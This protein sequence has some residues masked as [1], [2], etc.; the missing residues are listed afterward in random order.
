MY[1]VSGRKD[2]KLNKANG[3]LMTNV[4]MQNPTE[5]K[6][7]KIKEHFEKYLQAVVDKMTPQTELTEA[8]RYALLSGGKRWR[9]LLLFMIAEALG[10][11]DKLDDAAVA[12]EMFH[13]ASLIADDLPSMDND[14]FR[15]GQPTVHKKFGEA[16]AIMASYALISEGYSAIYRCTL[17]LSESGLESAET[18]GLLAV[19]CVAHNAGIQG[20]TGGQ[21]FDLK[22]QKFSQEE[23]L[24]IHRQ[25]TASIF[26]ISLVL[27]WLF[28]GG[29]LE[30]L[31]LVQKLAMNFGTAFQ[32]VDD[33]H[34]FQQDA[35]RL[36][37]VNY[38]QSFGVESAKSTIEKLVQ[39]CKALLE[40]L[41]IQDSLLNPLMQK[42]LD[43]A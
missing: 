38:A 20:A 40:K 1:K 21:F 35:D 39:E 32:I 22:E 29:D 37:T 43:H 3:F 27:G 4:Q 10:H 26:E 23:I 24:N 15:R 5:N 31:P 36:S 30:K 28:G 14:D 6:I 17:A 7:A 16:V 19:Q 41:G 8:C 34:D 25:K 12:V 11:N 9:P 42:L 2:R 33:L 13:T 18:R